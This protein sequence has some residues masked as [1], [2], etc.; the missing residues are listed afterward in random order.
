MCK[1]FLP[2]IDEHSTKTRED[3]MALEKGLDAVVSTQKR[4]FSEMFQFIQEAALL[5]ENQK[6]KIEAINR[7]YQVQCII[8]N[9]GCNR[10]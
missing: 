3:L 8:A 9:S 5:W 1:E 7:Q 4:H 6:N 2:L 10:E